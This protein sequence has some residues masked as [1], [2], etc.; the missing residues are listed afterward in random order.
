MGSMMCAQFVP[1]MTPSTIL[2]RLGL[3]PGASA[4]PGVLVPIN[5]WLAYGGDP[6]QPATNKMMVE[7]LGLTVNHTG[8][9]IRVSTGMVLGKK[10]ASHCSV[11]A[12]WWQW[13][14]L[15]KIKWGYASHINLLEMRMILHAILWKTRKPSSVNKRWLHL[16]DSMV[17]LLIL[18][19]GRTSSHMLQPVVRQIGA[20]QLAMGSQLLHGHVSSAE[21]PTDAASRT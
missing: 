8:C 17:C 12:L 7:Q 19:K 1:R 10:P 13:K 4:H 14:H 20:I 5:R 18:S 6:S 16:E 3:A 11:R 9:D 21:N 2:Q 15:F